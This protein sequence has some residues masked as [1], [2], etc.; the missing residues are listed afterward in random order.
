M[1]RGLLF[2]SLALVLGGSLV[3]ATAIASGPPTIIRDD[4]T[5]DTFVNPCNGETVT[6]TSG[7]FQIVIHET[8]TPSGGFHLIVEGNAQGVKG[9]GTSGTSYQ[10]PGGFWFELNVTPG[11]ETTT[12]TDVFNLVAKGS[13]PNFRVLGTFH[14]TI[15]AKGN[16][17]AFVDNFTETCIG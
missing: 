14:V 4:V 13:A 3:P 2:V 9:V 11:A 6:I 7:T 16:V 17:T 5:G 10:V 12:E 8:A 15:D 1:R